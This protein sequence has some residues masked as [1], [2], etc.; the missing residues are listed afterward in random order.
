MTNTTQEVYEQYMKI[1]KHVI[2][3]MI[4]DAIA[5][6]LNMNYKITYLYLGVETARSIGYTDSPASYQGIPVYINYT[7]PFY[8]HLKVTE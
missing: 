3:R 6:A 1:Q 5:T 4:E 7:Y 2:T 8:I